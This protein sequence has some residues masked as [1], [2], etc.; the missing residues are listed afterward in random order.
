MKALGTVRLSHSTDEST[1][2]VRQ[3]GRIDWWT[4]GQQGAVLVAVAED[5]DVSGAVSPFD[6]EQLGPWL[7]DDPPQA[8]DVLVA[9]KLDRVSRSAL[10]TLKLFEW[11]E[12]RGKRLVCVDD[13][14]DTG[15][16]MGRLFG[17]LAAIFAEMERDTIIARTRASRQE[18]RAQGRWAGGAP[19]FGYAAVQLDT[20]GWKLDKHPVEAP[21]VVEMA[22][23]VAQGASYESVAAWLTAEGVRTPR[24]DNR[25]NVW[26]GVTVRRLLGN[27]V[28][29]WGRLTTHGRVLEHVDYAEPLLTP[30]LA[31]RLDLAMQAR[32]RGGS[33]GRVPTKWLTG[34]VRCA[35]CG[36]NMYADAPRRHKSGTYSYYRCRSKIHPG[37]AGQACDMPN[38]RSEV[39]DEVVAREFLASVGGE[40]LVERVVVPGADRRAEL[41]SVKGRISRLAK[42]FDSGVLDDTDDDEFLASLAALKARRREIEAAPYVADAVEYQPT[43]VYVFDAWEESNNDARR[44]MLLDYGA[45]LDVRRDGTG[46]ERCRFSLWVPTAAAG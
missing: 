32:A 12:A 46:D 3:R 18:L 42:M 4:G 44:A 15:T 10:D 30:E 39:V 1:S 45:R 21:L 11:L 2:P 29:R 26:H 13:G 36:A 19:P 23:R 41:E 35:G 17:K 31:A 38:I 27:S 25:R 8:W 5:I 43:G 16:S 20:G 33:P 6:R 28:V 14:I 22:S 7:T 24:S 34:I 37:K 9:W 40:E